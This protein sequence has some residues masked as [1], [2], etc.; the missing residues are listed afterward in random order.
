[1]KN[2]PNLADLSLTTALNNMLNI[3]E[4]RYK[5]LDDATSDFDAEKVS[6]ALRIALRSAG[7]FK[8]NKYLINALQRLNIFYLKYNKSLDEPE[9]KRLEKLYIKNAENK[10]IWAMMDTMNRMD[11]MAF[12]LAEKALIKNNIIKSR[13]SLDPDVLKK[14][15][16]DVKNEEN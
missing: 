14:F 8:S 7:S 4:Q 2:L 10:L 5:A 3:L 6:K 12:S 15:K 1:M 16:R 11:A 9:V 13:F